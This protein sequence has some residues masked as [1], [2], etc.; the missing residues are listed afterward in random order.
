VTVIHLG[1][2]H[3]VTRAYAI[4]GLGRDGFHA[5][6]VP[7]DQVGIGSYSD[8]AFP[9]VQVEDFGCVGAGHS[10]KLVLI[11]LPSDLRRTITHTHTPKAG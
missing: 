2:V 7:D 9:G 1:W 8:A 11:H 3:E 10:H 4:M 6:R 5:V